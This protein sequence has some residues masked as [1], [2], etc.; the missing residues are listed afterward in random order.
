MISP[1]RK[2]HV[3][4]YAGTPLLQVIPYKREDITAE[5]GL[6]TQRD[7]GRADYTYRTKSPGFYRKWLHQ[8]KSV[9]ITYL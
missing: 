6:A 2:M 7:I 5:V 3:K 4:I 9:D 1:L 8:K